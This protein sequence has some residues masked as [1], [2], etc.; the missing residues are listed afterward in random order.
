MVELPEGWSFRD[1][2]GRRNLFAGRDLYGSITFSYDASG[3]SGTGLRSY[4]KEEVPGR[5][6]RTSFSE[7]NGSYGYTEVLPGGWRI[8]ASLL[9]YPQFKGKDGAKY[10]E[11]MLKMFSGCKYVLPGHGEA[12]EGFL[13]LDLQ[14]GEK[15]FSVRLGQPSGDWKLVGRKI[16]GPEGIAVEVSLVEASEG[17]A[18]MGYF[19][20]EVGSKPENWN[21]SASRVV[22]GGTGKNGGGV[23]MV[24]LPEF[25]GSGFLRFD[26]VKAITE[27]QKKALLP[28]LQAVVF[29]K[30]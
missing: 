20:D 18:W 11:E 7:K 2:D 4:K 16:A 17:Q 29:E 10:H 24:R 13:V 25:P 23:V 3:L 30:K 5:D 21:R 28:M 26:S 14:A 22:L 12:T 15:V 8:N 19:E 1:Q 27:A 9:P 6:I